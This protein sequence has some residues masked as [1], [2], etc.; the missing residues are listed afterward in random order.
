MYVMV[1]KKDEKKY[2]SKLIIYIE[3]LYIWFICITQKKRETIIF[4]HP[5][6][7]D[8]RNA[9]YFLTHLPSEIKFDSAHRKC[10][11]SRVLKN[12]LFKQIKLLIL[13]RKPYNLIICKLFVFSIAICCYKNKQM[14]VITYLKQYNYSKKK[15]MTLALNDP[16]RV[17]MPLNQPVKQNH[18]FIFRV[19]RCLMYW[20]LLLK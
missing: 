4:I 19:H 14:V 8:K 5:G 6:I 9:D 10:T 11:F 2:L 12:V 17:D 20:L 7:E 18:W 13:N 16:T 15:R 1:K 3:L